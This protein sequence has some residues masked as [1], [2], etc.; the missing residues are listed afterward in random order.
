M[1]ELLLRDFSKV[2]SLVW[3]IVVDPAS[4]P[5]EAMLIFGIMVVILVMLLLV[6]LMLVTRGTDDTEVDEASTLEAKVAQDIQASE[7]MIASELATPVAVRKRMPTGLIVVLGVLGWWL[8]TGLTTSAPAA[9]LS[10]HSDSSHALSQSQDDPHGSTSCVS[11]HES[12]SFLAGI[13]TSVPT[14]VAH[15]I[16]GI[17]SERPGGDYGYV[18]G[19]VCRACHDSDIAETT[20]DE[21]KA[22]RV[23]HAEPIEAGAQ[24]LD[25]HVLRDG[26]MGSA[27]TG[28]Q[29]CLRCHNDIDASAECA[30]C[31][32]DDIALAVAGRS[33]PSTAT[34]QALVS[35]PQCGGCHSQETCDACHGIRLPHTPEFMAYAH[36]REGVEDI[37]YNDGETCGKCH[38]TGHRACTTCHTGRFPSHGSVFAPRHGAAG[39]TSAG[40]DS[41]H[42]GMAY[43]SGRDF[44]VDLCHSTSGP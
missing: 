38:Y 24:C 37:W 33:E 19:N 34:A 7:G 29:P 2:P 20:T 32:V 10:C 44:C 12:G 18:A 27:T 3:E 41:C 28:M 11:C 17:A 5:V 21:V 42:A 30:Y 14:R 35:D 36:A 1:E 31:H 15:I 26:I 8:A 16:S 43:Q 22:V 39:A 13:T 9:C 40:C 4:R 25:C 6:V 23:S